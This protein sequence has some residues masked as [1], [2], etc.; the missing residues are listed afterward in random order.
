MPFNIKEN[1]KDAKYS[2]YD[3]IELV[4]ILINKV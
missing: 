2:K 4:K 3:I 1:F